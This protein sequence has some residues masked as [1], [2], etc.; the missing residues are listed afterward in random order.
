MP[1]KPCDVVVLLSG[2]GSNLQALIDSIR[3]GDSPVRIRAVISN[4][5]DAYG[6]QRAQQAGIDTAVLD[7]KAF[8]GREAFDA[9]LV[10]LIDGYQPQLVVLA[11]FM[12]ILSAGFVRHYQGRLLNIHPSLLPKYK[13]LHTHQR[14]LEAGDKEHGCSVHFVTEEL[15]G[16]PLVVQAVIPVELDDTPETLAQRVHS[17]EHQI[18]PLAVH[19]FAE[20]R[21][22]LGEHGALLDDQPLAASGHLI[23]P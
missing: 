20:G 15:D 8:E 12:R 5:A 21:L 16:G 23:R 14:A 7:H 3:T 6:L 11:G 22:R 18:Y 4:R 17:Q 10:E 13:G 9:A 1:S 2:T 19:W